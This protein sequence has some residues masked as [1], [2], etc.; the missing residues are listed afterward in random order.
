MDSDTDF[1]LQHSRLVANHPVLVLRAY[2]RTSSPFLIT[3]LTV[4]SQTPSVVTIIAPAV[5]IRRTESNT[6]SGRRTKSREILADPVA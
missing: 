1:L 6:M 4:T 2:T 5:Y 3:A